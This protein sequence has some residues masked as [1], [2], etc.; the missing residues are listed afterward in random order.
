M[1]TLRIV[2]V[3]TMLLGT[4]LV[5]CA[6]YYQAEGTATLAG[7]ENDLDIWLGR[8]KEEQFQEM[9]DPEMCMMMSNGGEFCQWVDPAYSPDNSSAPKRVFLYDQ[10]G[11]ICG[12]T[13]TGQWANQTKDLCKR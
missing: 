10:Q 13:Y 8:T 9:G 6:M 5:G 11:T 2:L 3:S 1:F 4:G 7:V 12:W